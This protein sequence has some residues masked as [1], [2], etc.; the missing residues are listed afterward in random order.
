MRD[1]IHIL[2]DLTAQIRHRSAG[3]PL[4]EPITLLLF[5]AEETITSMNKIPFTEIFDDFRIVSGKLK[6]RGRA[7]H[8]LVRSRWSEGW[9]LPDF[10]AV[11]RNCWAAWKDDPGMRR[12]FRSAT[13]YRAS[14]FEG[15]VNMGQNKSTADRLREI[16]EDA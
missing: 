1:P 11:H 16:E 13:L 12:F 5:E 8:A 4:P 7:A 6:P 9:R 15:Y 14:K 2:A 3:R 10:K